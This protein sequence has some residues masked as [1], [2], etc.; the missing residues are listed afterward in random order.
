[1]DKIT[2]TNLVRQFRFKELFNQMGWDNANEKFQIDHK[3]ISYTISA[4]CE[5]SG[6]RF[7]QCTPPDG[8]E[9]PP[10]NDRMRIQSIVKRRYYEHLLIFTDH[11]RQKQIWQYAY[12]PAGKPIKT[13]VTEYYVQQDPQLLFQ[14]TSGLVFTIDEQEDITLVDVTTRMSAAVDQ[15]SERVTKKFYDGFKKQHTKFLSFISGIPD[16]FD[17]NWYTSVMLN[18]LMFCYFIQKRGFLDGNLDYLMHKL[19]TGRLIHGADKFY[20]FYRSFL[21]QLFHNV[22]G[23]PEREEQSAEFGKIPFLNG[24]IFSVHELEAKYEGEIQI[25]DDAFEALFNFFDEYNWHLD[26]NITATGKDINPDVIGYIFEKYINDRAQMGAYY[27]KED[28]TDYIGKNT[29]IPHLFDEVQRNYPQAFQPDAEIWQKLKASEDQY[30]HNAV[31]HGIN[32]KDIWQ[33][34]PEDIKAGLNP[35]QENLVEL[36]RSWNT[37]A[38]EELALPTEIWRETIARRQRYLELRQLISNGDILQINDL[39]THNLDIRQFALDLINETSDSK[40]VYNFYKA[41]KSVTILDPTCGSGA[42]LFAAMNILEDLYEACI[43]RMGDFVEDSSAYSASHLKKELKIVDDPS[44]PNLQYFIYKSIILNNLYGVDIMNE[45]VE[46]AKLRLFLKLVACVDPDQADPNYGLEPLPDI[47]F[48]IRCGNTLVG[49][50]TWDEIIEDIESDVVNAVKYKE[51]IPQMCEQVALTFKRFKELQL[52]GSQNEE[53]F[54]PAKTELSNRLKELTSTLD[55]MLHQHSAT[56]PFDEW[57]KSNQPFHWYA[58][59]YEIIHHN[60]GFDVIIGNPPYVESRKIGYSY[61]VRDIQKCGNLY[62]YVMHRSRLLQNKKAYFGMIIPISLASTPRMSNLRY[63][64]TQTSGTLWCSNFADRPGCL[65]KGVHQKLSVIICTM[66]KKDETQCNLYTTQYYHWYSS[67][68]SALEE[69]M[70]TCYYVVNSERQYGWYKFGSNLDTQILGKLTKKLNELRISSNKSYSIYLNMRMMYWCK[71]FVFPIASNEYKQYGYSDV[72]IRDAACAAFNST[73]FFWL[74]EAISDVWHITNKELEAF[75]YGC[76]TN[77]FEYIEEL[78]KVN[79]ILMS[80]LEKNKKFVQTKQTDYEYYHR[81][82]KS[83]LDNLD[84]VLGQLLNLSK[85]EVDYI[86]NYNLKY[87]MSGSLTNSE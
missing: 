16:E 25:K 11:K 85:E 86:I 62:A 34:L 74:W 38:P 22:L 26:T 54:I 41:L 63:Y 52:E 15:N 12:R 82:S 68:P 58:E 83:I 56:K 13:V 23:S 17:K 59:F 21:L 77:N 75:N 3:D 33:D 72:Q 76:L 40:L 69:L 44:H 5:K 61:N 64:F 37:A 30:I 79:Q 73:L 43:G 1:M 27:T 20:T 19:E 7:L 67:H 2:F 9:I 32:P 35:R 81:L 45:A 39:I 78:S 42:F 87:R 66:K 18:R 51:S 65:F 49:Y 28:I 29:I 24:G 4:I 6:F 84:I 31:K 47:D 70:S 80:D 55:S 36:R 53:S 14:R 50:T 57:K 60:Q 71:C 10:K 46:I 48:N 8:M